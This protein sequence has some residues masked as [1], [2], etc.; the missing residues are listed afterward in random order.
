MTHMLWII[1][2][3]YWISAKWPPVEIEHFSRKGARERNNYQKVENS[4]SYN[5]SD[6]NIWFFCCC[7]Q[8]G[9]EFWSRWSSCH[10]SGTSDVFRKIQFLLKGFHSDAARRYISKRLLRIT[11][12]LQRRSWAHQRIRKLQHRSLQAYLRLE[13]LQANQRAIKTHRFENQ[14]QK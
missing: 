8:W 10:K 12:F 6:A 14:P 7:C 9:K 4:W 11:L 3:K 13:R 1:P 5:G 2:V